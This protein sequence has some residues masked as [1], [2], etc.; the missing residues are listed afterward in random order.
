MKAV[1]YGEEDLCIGLT[2]FLAE[3]GVRPV[4]VATG[5]RN[6]NLAAHIKAACGSVLREMPIIREGADFFDI[7]EE[8]KTL[9]PDLLVGHSKGQGAAREWNIPLLRVGFPIHDRFGGQRLLHL[10]YRGAQNL[11]D[12]LVNLVLEKKQND[13][14]IGYGY[15]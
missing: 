15:L 5:A 13:S 10:G 3:I 12:R 6:R 8:A 11:F 9:A 7:V 4:L 1:I 2:S 14:D